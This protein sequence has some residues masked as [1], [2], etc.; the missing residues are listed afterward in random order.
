MARLFVFLY[1]A[2]GLGVVSG[3]DDG[4]D[5]SFGLAD[6]SAGV[7]LD[8]DTRIA[9]STGQA[10]SEA[11]VLDAANAGS[12]VVTVGE[13]GI[14]NYSDDQGA[15]WQQAKVPVNVLLTAIYFADAN[16]GWAVGH[17][18]VILA[19][20]DA[21]ATWA[22][23]N[24]SPEL[25]TPLLDVWFADARRGFAVGGT[26]WVFAT[27][28]GGASW[29][30]QEVSAQVEEIDIPDAFY[31]FAPHFFAIAALDDTLFLAGE[32]GILMRSDD[33]GRS[34]LQLESP[35]HG[36]FFGLLNQGDDLVV[37]GLNGHLFRSSD[38]GVSWSA[39]AG[40]GGKSLFTAIAL[41][42]GHI[43]LGGGAG[44]LL[45]VS[46][47]EGG[48]R[49]VRSPDRKDVLALVA[50]DAGQALAFTGGGGA[51]RRLSKP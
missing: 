23:Q 1:I 37:F 48:A 2:F 31:D 42:N 25:D 44:T 14:I 10:T 47:D 12:R 16:H 21:G 32:K 26:G 43:L 4:P 34:W 9:A 19:T 49:P 36:T 17:D 27:E 8:V 3:A 50:I 22:L 11:L 39:I 38:R 15:S 24:Y 7:N 18:A 41:E 29:N 20:T 40:G 45:E 13:R 28:D 35:Y 5:E 30:R 46:W 51:P 33:A 6:E